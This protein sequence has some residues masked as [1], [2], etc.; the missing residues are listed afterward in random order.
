MSYCTV[1]LKSEIRA[2]T[3]FSIHFSPNSS[4]LKPQIKFFL[5]PSKFF[6]APIKLFLGQIKFSALTGSYL[7]Y[8]DPIL[9]GFRNLDIVSATVQPDL[10]KYNV[11]IL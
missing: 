11:K 7:P 1:D 10:L 9:T 3:Q 6:L 5:A 2:I 4:H 8:L